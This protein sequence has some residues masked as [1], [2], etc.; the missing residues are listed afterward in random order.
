LRTRVVSGCNLAALVLSRDGVN[1]QRV[2]FLCTGNSCRSQMAEAL[3]RHLG[4]EQFEAFSAGSRP[5]AEV[6]PLAIEVMNE[7][8]IDI[9][10][11]QSKPVTLFE[12]QTFDCL[13]TVCDSARE[14]CPVFAG[15]TE[16]LHWSF[17]DPAQAGG[18]QEQKRRVF[19]RV[20]DEIRHRI[21][22]FLEA[23]PAGASVH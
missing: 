14:S 17:E 10:G 11:A 3:L 19:R 22:R 18:D 5:A 21:R 13:I 2:L 6:H 8:G 20:R 4:G 1:K 9:R 23:R 16:Q 15:A 12:G 7:A